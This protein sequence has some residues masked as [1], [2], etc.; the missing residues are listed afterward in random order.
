MKNKKTECI[1]IISSFSCSS[2]P[3]PPVG[4][5][6]LLLHSSGCGSLVLGSSLPHKTS[7]LYL[8][9]GNNFGLEDIPLGAFLNPSSSVKGGGHSREEN[10]S[11]QKLPS[12]CFSW[13]L[14]RPRNWT[15]LFH[16]RGCILFCNIYILALLHYNFRDNFKN[17]AP[18][19]LVTNCTSM[20]DH[21]LRF[22]L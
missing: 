4:N 10:L 12:V 1:Q 14:T 8:Q 17:H 19:Q 11:R 22:F 13:T 3:P 9:K 2:F 21:N 15:S 7:H 5:W 16:S 20:C 18:L 6:C